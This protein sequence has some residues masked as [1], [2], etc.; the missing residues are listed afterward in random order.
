LRKKRIP[1]FLFVFI[2][3]CVLFPVADYVFSKPI[4]VWSK[5]YGG[6]GVDVG[7]SVQQTI[8]DGYIIAGY[9][10]SFGEGDYDVYLVKT[11]PDGN[12]L[13]NKTFG[14]SKH[15]FGVSVQQTNDDGY[16]I[17]GDTES[18][19]EGEY[20][21][22]LVKT[23]PDGNM[24]WNRTFGGS[25]RDFGYSIQNTNDDG[26]II[27]GYTGSFGEGDLNIY[28]IKLVK[29][30]KPERELGPEYDNKI[31]SFPPVSLFLGLIIIIL[32]LRA[33][34][35]SGKATKDVSLTKINSNH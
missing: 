12:M 29:E 32:W 24:L 33:N 14:G 20:D 31:P 25:G 35:N 27:A 5:T 2:V 4:E 30:I 21:V 11:D 17:T 28:L 23:D 18:F 8:D 3:V 19:G 16:I 22:Y 9:T 10:D 13:W 7:K 26:Y 34:S 1:I 15:D 6:I